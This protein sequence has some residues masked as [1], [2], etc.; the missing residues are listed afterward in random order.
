MQKTRV[1]AWHAFH[2]DGSRCHRAEDTHDCP[3][4][5]RYRESLPCSPDCPPMCTD[6]HY[7]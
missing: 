4:S 3:A 1:V 5:H 7:L 2:I 6:S